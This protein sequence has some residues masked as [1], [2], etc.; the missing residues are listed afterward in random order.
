[1][2]FTRQG[3]Q[4]LIVLSLTSVFLFQFRPSSVTPTTTTAVVRVPEDARDLQTAI[5]MVP[6]GGTID[7]A[8]GTYTVPSGGFVISDLGKGFT[9]QARSGSPVVL[10]GQ[11]QHPIIRFINSDRSR[12]KRVTF[13]GLTFA[14]GYTTTDG[15]AGGVTMQRAEAVFINCRFQGNTG[16]QPSTGGG[17]ILV[18]ENSMAQFSNCRWENNSAR[19]FGGGLAV[20]TGSQASILSST[21]DGNRVDV[22][23]HSVTAAGGAIHVGNSTLTV[24]HST[25]RNNRAGYVGGAIYAV[26]TWTDSTTEPQTFVSIAYSTFENNVA[27]RDATVSFSLPTEGG[28]LHFEDQTRALVY[29]STFIRNSAMVGGGINLYRA[30]VSV[31]ASYLRGNTATGVGPANGFGGALSATSNDTPADG[32]HNRPSARLTVKDTVIQG[33]FVS[34]A[35]SGLYAA[36]DRHRTY[37]EGGVAQMGSV[38]ENRARVV[39]ENVIFYNTDV[40]ET[41]GSPGTGVGGGILVDLAD[42]TLK[43]VL[44]VE[45]D[46]FGDSNSSGGGLAALNQSRVQ[47][48]EVYFVNNSSEKYGGALFVQGSEI[49][50]SQCVL[51]EN[52]ISPGVAEDLYSSYGAAIFTTPD[53]GRGIPVSGAVEDCTISHNIGL[54]IFDDDRNDGPINAVQYNGNTIYNTTFGNKVYRNSLGICCLTVAE[55]NSLI[56]TRSNGTSSDKSTR[57]NVEPPAQPTIGVIQVV[58]FYLLPQDTSHYVGVAWSGQAAEFNGTSLTQKTLL[59][60]G[61]TPRSYSLT[62]DNQSFNAQPTLLDRQVFIPLVSR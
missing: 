54:P 4:I 24:A 46:A 3:F 19:N 31:I 38:M 57:N 37:G 47:G 16:N 5:S 32:T 29:R 18:A 60:S 59:T 11:G 12:G 52:E 34:Q 55:L 20:E 33:E 58:P 50:L 56:V 7:V 8:A 21:F 27:Q 36:G 26:G 2:G 43:K 23:Y 35:G 42:L 1:M 17:G 30:N 40:Q 51:A 25:F 22:P 45:S 14:N 13:V 28:A 9:I 15:W 61:T 41:P 10:D 44:V 6:D 53:T 39:L 48:S 62:V 49:Y